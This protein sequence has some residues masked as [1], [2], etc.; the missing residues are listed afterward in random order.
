MSSKEKMIHP[1]V[2]FL[3]TSL[4]EPLDS[5][6][7]AH[8]KSLRI[9]IVT[10]SFLPAINGVTNSVL[11][12][13]ENMMA[14]GHHVEV[15]APG[16]GPTQYNGALVHRVP[17]VA[18]P[19]YSE[20]RIGYSRKFTLQALQQI[21][22]D[23]V[24]IAS[25]TVLGAIGISVS[26]ELGIPTVAIYQT[27]LAGFANRY[28]LGL[29]GRGIWRHL[30]RVHRKAS[31]TLAPSTDAVWALRQRSVDN[32]VRWM[33]GV[34]TQRFHPDHHST[35]IRSHLAPNG[36]V[37]VGYVGRLAREKR[38]D[39]LA[40]IAHIP[41]VKLVIVGDG[42]MRDALERQIPNAVFVGFKGGSEL[43]NYF[44]SLDVF[45]HAGTD[46]T[47]CQ[48]V[49]EALASGVPVV[50]PAVGGPLDLVQHGVNG[51]LWTESSQGSLKGA[52]E[53]LVHFPVKRERMA[54][55]AR[56]SVEERTW[57]SVMDELEGHYRTVVGGL[58]FAYKEMAS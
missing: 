12:V 2:R 3:R 31:L 17:S 39:L 54:S 19:A 1:S 10:E 22:P 52:V 57:P 50:A 29:A 7:D 25:P 44:A 5:C 16:P 26:T 9:A 38:V 55:R 53:E 48:A 24:H 4:N 33:R 40:P 51:Y 23:I 49:Q 37:L 46:E 45:V 15:I 47:F 13:I 6:G 8:Q 21:Q 43:G 32:V 18:L 30:A 36:E 27:D 28:H 56:A 41:G 14:R 34:D 42:P 11:R 58:S 35:D 20:L